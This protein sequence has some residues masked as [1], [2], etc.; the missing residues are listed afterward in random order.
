MKKIVE[1]FKAFI[2]KGNVLDLAVGMIIG[3]AFTAIVKSLVDDVI[4]PVLSL[5][6][7]KVDFTNLF[8]ALNGQTDATLEAAKE[9]GAVVAYGNFIMA[10]VNF[11][12]VALVIFFIVKGANK[13]K[14]KEEEAPKP[15][16]EPSAE[17]KL[18]TE[19][20]DLLKNQEK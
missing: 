13:M 19:I 7:G 6:T 9:A 3:A 8:I 12:L 4:M 15:A 16:P 5:I 11:L 10:I 17:E 18:L 2:A 1:E 20:R 14:K